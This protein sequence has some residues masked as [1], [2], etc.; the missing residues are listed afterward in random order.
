[1]TMGLN[2]VSAL[3]VVNNL[4]EINLKSIIK[5]LGGEKEAAKIAKNIVK[6][7]NIKKLLIQMT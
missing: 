1:M 6:H 5:F 7:R 2:K 4:S 3:D